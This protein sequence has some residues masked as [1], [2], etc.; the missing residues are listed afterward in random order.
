[1]PPNCN[2]FLFIS[3][4][5]R[6]INDGVKC[7][8]VFKDSFRLMALP[9]HLGRHPSPQSS[10]E[11]GGDRRLG[12]SSVGLHRKSGRDYSDGTKASGVGSE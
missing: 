1:M 3:E 12:E 2:K 6:K 11:A 5:H 8:H 9:I 7:R 4:P 10:L